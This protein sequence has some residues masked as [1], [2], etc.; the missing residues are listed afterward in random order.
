MEVICLFFPAIFFCEIRNRIN[1][2]GYGFNLKNLCSLLAEYVCGNILINAI[3][4]L[5]RL[6]LKGSESNF[7]QYISE[8]NAFALKYLVMAITLA[9]VLPYIEKYVREHMSLKIELS[10]FSYSFTLADKW[11]KR[12]VILTAVFFAANNIV[13]MFNNSVWGDEGIVVCLSRCTWSDMLI[14]VAHNG[15]SPLFYAVAWIFVKLFGESGFVFHLSAT[16]AYFII[17][18]LSVTII[19]KWFGNKAA[20][21]FITLSSIL[22]CAVTYNMEIRMYAWCE[23]FILLAFLMSYKIYQTQKLRYYVLM[24]VFS[25]AGAYSH[26]Y[27]LPSVGIM[28]FVLLI[29]SIIRERKR[30]IAV[31]VSGISVL[32]MLI[33]W[34]FLADKHSTNGGVI[35]DYG[36][37]LVSL[38]ECVEFIFFSKYS[39]LL[40]GLFFVAILL[41]FL[42]EHKIVSLEPGDDGKKVIK[43]QL[44]RAIQLKSEW[45]WVI[46]G[47]LAVFGTIALAQIFSHVFYPIICLRYLYVSYVVIWLLMGIAV[48]KLQFSRVWTTMLILMLLI[49]CYPS[50]LYVTKDELRNSERLEVTLELTQPEMDENDFIY[51]D[52][53]HFEW[54]VATSYYPNTPHNIFGAGWGLKALPELDSETQYWLFLSQPVSEDITLNLENQAKKAELVIDNGYIGT[55]DVWVYKVIDIE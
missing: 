30:I 16:L 48:S 37:D 36:I 9:V 45:F 43:I 23:L 24:A 17:L 28:Y 22:D 49:T 29:Y 5:G 7:Y 55:G 35:N 41:W 1:A 25:I 39:L 18:I 40:L 34:V 47:I 10:K 4:I 44:F 27:A 51:T 53:G 42:Y 21:I 52:I 38:R 11:K 13:R 15:H 3:I 32:G 12:I 2:K 46:S 8:Y 31:L 26:Y 19:R 20:I 50:F 6:L 14:G 54:T 33:P